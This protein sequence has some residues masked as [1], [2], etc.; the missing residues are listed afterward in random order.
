MSAGPSPTKRGAAPMLR[1]I[2][3][4]ALAVVGCSTP[5]VALFKVDPE[6]LRGLLYI[7]IGSSPSTSHWGGH[8]FLLNRPGK[9]PLALTAYHVA[10]D[11]GFV[12]APPEAAPPVT[13][14]LVSPVNSPGSVR[15]GPPRAFPNARTSTSPRS[16]LA[17]AAFTGIDWDPTLA[18]TLA[19][20][21]PAVGDTVFVLAVHY[22]D[23]PR[24]GPR[25]HPAR[26]T[27]SSA[28]RFAY[29]YLASANTNMTSG[30]AVLTRSGQVVAVN[31]GTI[32]DNG[33]VTGLG[34]GVESIRALLAVASP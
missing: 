28:T 29:V 17:L 26:V 31:A 1:L 15:L 34:V 32:V 8:G 10:G 11:A 2:S 16:Q 7:H 33:S 12:S 19:E 25:R 4:L 5:T 20:S 24:G 22:G 6:E 23:D 13:A 14:F 30:A 27:T 3:T 21:L 9:E 18:F